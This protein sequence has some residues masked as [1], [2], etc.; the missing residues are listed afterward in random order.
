MKEESSYARKPIG[1]FDAGPG[2]LA[3]LKY[4][5]EILPSENVIYLGDTARQPYG[6]QSEEKVRQYTLEGCRF[7]ANNGAKAI[8]IGRNTATVAGLKECIGEFPDIP[9]LGMI[10]PGVKAALRKKTN[11]LIGVWGTELTVSSHAYKKELIKR[12]PNC[13]VIETAPVELLR[14]AEK[15]KIEDKKQIKEII[16]RYLQ[17]FKNRDLSQ[18]IF[19]CTDLTCVRPEVEEVAGPGIQIIDPAEEIVS[20]LRDILEK[21]CLLNNQ[22]KELRLYKIYITGKDTQQFSVFVEEFL[23]IKSQEVNQTNLQNY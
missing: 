2:G 10:Q 8:L 19:G 13:Q 16:R 12:A 17:Q 20:E 7:L 3:V 22:A 6:P 1:I 4:L 15:G 9:V 11:G 21:D 14:L 5:M 18:L 23:G